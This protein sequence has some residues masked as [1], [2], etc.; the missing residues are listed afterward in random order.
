MLEL[1]IFVG[2]IIYITSHTPEEWKKIIDN[3]EE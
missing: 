1:I 2:I 3:L